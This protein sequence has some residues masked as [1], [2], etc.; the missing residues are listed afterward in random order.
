MKQKAYTSLKKRGKSNFKT[1]NEYCDGLPGTTNQQIE[2]RNTHTAVYQTQDMAEQ[3]SNFRVPTPKKPTDSMNNNYEESRSQTTSILKRDDL[4]TGNRTERLPKFFDM[5][6]D[7]L[8]SVTFDLRGISD[9]KPN[10][11]GLKTAQQ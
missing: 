3:V 9:A 8:Q 1:I 2:Y 6:A 11:L 10:T 5:R 7:R 4:T